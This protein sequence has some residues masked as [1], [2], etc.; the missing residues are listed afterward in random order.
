MTQEI[1]DR[2]KEKELTQAA[3][4]MVKQHHAHDDGSEVILTPVETNGI[5]QQ[6]IKEENEWKLKTQA[7]QKQN[8]NDGSSK[9]PEKAEEAP[10]EPIEIKKEEKTVVASC[11]CGE[12]FAS[13]FSRGSNT[14]EIKI[15]T[16]DA[17]GSPAKTYSVSSSQQ[18]DYSASGPSGTDYSKQ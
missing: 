14:S 2:V 11:N 6:L 12:I 3:I 5:E 4:S 1:S 17:S 13:T 16:Y 8:F 7:A 9:Q 10:Q 18:D 15:K